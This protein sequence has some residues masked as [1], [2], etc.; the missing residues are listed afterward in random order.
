MRPH[1][2]K[3]L[4][5]LLST[6]LLAV[7]LPLHAQATVRDQKPFELYAE[8]LEDTRVVLSDNA[9]WMMD[10]GDCFPTNTDYPDAT[11]SGCRTAA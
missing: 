7:G 5:L 6:L 8:F 1:A 3:T 4:Y 9:V 11:R 10:K 2:V